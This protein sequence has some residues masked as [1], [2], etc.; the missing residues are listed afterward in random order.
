MELTQ[1]QLEIKKAMR[2]FMEREVAP[3]INEWEENE[4]LP[5]SI[6]QKLADAGYAGLEAP[7]E[8]GG[9]A[10]GHVSQSLVF[11]ELGRIY[12]PLS[13]ISVHNMVVGLISRFGRPQQ[14]ENWLPKLVSGEWWAVFALTEP[15]AGSDVLAGTAH[16]EK[17]DGKWVINGTKVFIS[18]ADRA[19]VIAVNV[20]TEPKDKGKASRS[21]FLVPKGT[22]GMTIPRWEKKMGYNAHHTCQLDFV[23]CIVDDEWLIGTRGEGM[24]MMLSSL[25]KSRVNVGSMAVGASEAC[26]E[27]ALNYARD[28]KQFGKSIG[29]FQAIQLKLADMATRI[30]AAKLLVGDTAR[31]LDDGESVRAECSMAKYFATDVGNWVAS[32]AVQ[33]LGGYGYLRDFIV[34]RHYR[35]AKLGQIVEG[36][37]EIHRLQ[38]ARSLL[39]N[40]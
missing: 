28:R 32:E 38:V 16:A 30:R 9:T 13:F 36:T 12:R 10:L 19:D 24:K 2:S 5:R 33:I 6:F 29:E 3:N 23:D 25:N 18:N 21:V 35:E 7:S 31:R 8:F 14:R 37:N 34:E 11:E 17:R 26:L 27:I 4:D 40:A 22:P 20:L 15:D 39:M 1:E